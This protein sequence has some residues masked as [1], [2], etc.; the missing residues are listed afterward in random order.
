MRVSNGD[1]SD[2]KELVSQKS[3]HK[4][5]MSSPTSVTE[6]EEPKDMSGLYPTYQQYKALSEKMTTWQQYQWTL[7]LMEI[8]LPPG[9]TIPRRK[10]KVENPYAHKAKGYGTK[11]LPIKFGNLKAKHAW[12]PKVSK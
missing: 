2:C 3:A 9:S 7:D 4:N 10:T 1:T 11:V 12:T 6:M 8:C 5:K